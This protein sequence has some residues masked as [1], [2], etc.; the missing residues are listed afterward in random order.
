MY[1]KGLDKL[2]FSF[3]LIFNFLNNILISQ[4]YI[5]QSL[6]FYCFYDFSSFLVLVHCDLKNRRKIPVVYNC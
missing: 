3:L 4:Y 5:V 2:N 6:Y 1:S